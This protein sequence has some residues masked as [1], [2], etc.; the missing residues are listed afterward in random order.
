MKTA[1]PSEIKQLRMDA[2]LTQL[3]AGA[4]VGVKDRTWRK[5]ENGERGMKP[6]TFELFRL[7]TKALRLKNKGFLP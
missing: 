4:I 3:G 5:W 7:K 2:G 1:D 6:A